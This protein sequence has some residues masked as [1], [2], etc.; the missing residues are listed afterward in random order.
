M[1]SPVSAANICHWTI[2]V[3]S[4]R[5]GSDLRRLGYCPPIQQTSAHSRNP[6][7]RREG[8]D[9]VAASRS[10]LPEGSSE[11]SAVTLATS[12]P[13]PIPQHRPIARK[14]VL[15]RLLLR[16][17]C[18]AMQQTRMSSGATGIPV[19]RTLAVV[20]KIHRSLLSHLARNEGSLPAC[21]VP[22]LYLLVHAK[23]HQQDLRG[24][25]SADGLCS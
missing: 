16:E 4:C 13:R 14:S 11:T 9:G 24:P 3:H 21:I 18:G 12:T 19:L 5:R 1:T 17:L 15:A 25:A 2:A 6:R 10:C 23:V 22:L 7:R 8:L 20:T